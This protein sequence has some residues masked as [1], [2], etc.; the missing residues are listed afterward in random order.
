MTHV[1][2]FVAAALYS[3][4]S[5]GDAVDDKSYSAT[6][7]NRSSADATNTTVANITAARLADGTVADYAGKI[8][9]FTLFALI[10]TLSA[11]WAVAFAGLLLTMNRQYIGT[12][13]SLQTGCAYARSQFID[14]PGDDARRIVIF[15]FNER[16]WRSI[17]D[18][19]R[20][21]A[22][23]AYAMWL[24]LSPAW[25]TNAVRSLMPDDFIPAA[26]VQQLDARTPAG[27]RPSIA[28]IGALRRMSLAFVGQA[29]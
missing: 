27:R 29:S 24:Q 10:L 13:V 12:F 25:F 26:E 8:D 16:Q 23:G 17:R 6:G 28:N 18:L 4:Y 5:S 2:C 11:V 3:A 21:W 1:A 14:H 7:G 9:N 19:V 20:Q 15:F 22:L